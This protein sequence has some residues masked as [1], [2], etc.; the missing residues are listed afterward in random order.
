[1]DQDALLR[2]K[3]MKTF[4]NVATVVRK[5][6]NELNIS[7]QA[8]SDMLGYRN[9]QFVSNVERGLCSVP[10]KKVKEVAELLKLDPEDLIEAILADKEKELRDECYG[11]IEERRESANEELVVGEIRHQDSSA[12]RNSRGYDIPAVPITIGHG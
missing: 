5:R 11:S 7:Q 3:K 10:T 4:K 9:G 8:L 12:L 2:R 6:R 1:M